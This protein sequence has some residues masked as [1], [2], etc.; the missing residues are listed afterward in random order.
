MNH[1]SGLRGLPL[2]MVIAC[3]PFTLDD[4]LENDPLKAFLE[5]LGS[6]RI[7]VMILVFKD[8]RSQ[9]FN[10]FVDYTHSFLYV[11]TPCF[12][13]GT[14]YKCYKFRHAELRL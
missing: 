9:V 4:N 14:F 10:Q 8:M 12:V 5:G 3:G 6:E 13:D 2:Q 7:D 1:T 11:T